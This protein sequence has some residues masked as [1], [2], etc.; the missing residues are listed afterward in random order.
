MSAYQVA[1][2]GRK[3][4]VT[5]GEGGSLSIDGK[6]TPFECIPLRPG[7]WLLRVDGAPHEIHLPPGTALS[8]ADAPATLLVD[9]RNIEI[10]MQD[11]RHLLARKFGA[12][13][14]EAQQQ[15]QIRAPMP[16]LVSRILVKPGDTIEAGAGVLVLEAMKMENELKSPAAGTIRAVL[17]K[18]RDSVEKNAVLLELH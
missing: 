4:L 1:V 10:R 3:F 13:K 8:G 12:Q 15:R 7:T 16:G 9:G 6:E 18:E 2:G 14:G 5:I 17:V 11:E